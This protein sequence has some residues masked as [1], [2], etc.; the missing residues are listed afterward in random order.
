MKKSL[1]CLH[2]QLTPDHL[3][4][5]SH[6]HPMPWRNLPKRL[7]KSH[8]RSME[9]VSHFWCRCPLRLSLY[10]A[11]QQAPHAPCC[12]YTTPIY[13]LL[14]Y[15]YNITTYNYHVIYLLVITAWSNPCPPIDARASTARSPV[16]LTPNHTNKTEFMTWTLLIG[17]LWTSLLVWTDYELSFCCSDNPSALTTTSHS[18]V[19]IVGDLI[20]T[21]MTLTLTTHYSQCKSHKQRT[22][23]VVKDHLLQLCF[24]QHPSVPVLKTLRFRNFLLL[25]M[26]VKNVV[27]TITR[28]TCPD[29]CPRIS[30]TQTHHPCAASLL[31]KSTQYNNDF[32][33][34]AAHTGDHTACSHT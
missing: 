8:P 19:N 5:A 26:T 7:A 10:P 34:T 33:L 27:V 15:I 29:V 17:G 20:N 11:H 32:L 3:Y 23:L 13:L 24:V 1:P 14:I 18:C 31:Q 12:V 9:S 28:W 25:R 2:Q 22:H 16:L 21:S 30:A 6:R 4:P